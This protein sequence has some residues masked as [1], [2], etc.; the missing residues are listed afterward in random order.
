MR[1][2]ITPPEFRDRH[3]ERRQALVDATDADAPTHYEVELQRRDGSRF[4]A[5]ATVSKV[6]VRGEQLLAGFIRDVTDRKR[7]QDEREALLREQAARAEA[8]RVAELV[9]GMQLLVDAALAHRTL[10]EILSDLVTRVRAVL[11]A[12]AAAIYLAADQAL[13][14]AAA[15]GGDGPTSD[16]RAAARSARASPGAS[17]S[18]REPMLVQDP[19]TGRAALRRAARARDRLADRAAAARRGRGD[20]RARAWAPPR[21]GTS[22][23]TTSTCCGWPPTAWRSRS[24]TRACT[25]ASTGSRRRSSAACC[26]S[27]CRSCRGCRS[28]PATCRPRR[29]PRSAATGTTCCRPRAAASA[30]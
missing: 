11:D 8:E 2:L 26:R 3:D 14:L 15:S 18:E 27:A 23:P 7:R 4:P 22:P 28:R 29:R 19:P 30:S 21:R 24:T 1:T 6:D 9:S 10:D 25:S 16:E 20:R 12:D 13:T 5:E 17:P